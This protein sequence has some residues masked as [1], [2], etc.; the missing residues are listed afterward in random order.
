MLVWEKG[1]EDQASHGDIGVVVID[2]DAFCQGLHASVTFS[3]EDVDRWK[4]EDRDETSVPEQVVPESGLFAEAQG[5]KEEHQRKDEVN[6][7]QPPDPEL[8]K[9]WRAQVQNEA[10]GKQQHSK[11]KRRK[12]RI[13][14]REP[15]HLVNNREE[16]AEDYIF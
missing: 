9:F 15:A 16:I 13:Q 11:S 3:A 10:Q 6:Q 2:I 5:Q 1:C 8:V 7:Q 12:R 14:Q 4:D